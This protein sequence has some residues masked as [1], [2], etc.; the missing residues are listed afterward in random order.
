MFCPECGSR[1]DDASKFCASC[2][3]ALPTIGTAPQQARVSPQAVQAQPRGGA[4]AGAVA[5]R[6]SSSGPIA[7]AIVAIAILIAAAILFLPKLMGGSGGAAGGFGVEQSAIEGV[8]PA[9]MDNGVEIRALA[10]PRFR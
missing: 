2:G 4:H 5:A 9:V 6:K 10:R 7:I 3:T 1:N 8:Q